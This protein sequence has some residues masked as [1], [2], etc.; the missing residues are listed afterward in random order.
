MAQTQMQDEPLILQAEEKEGQTSEG[1][2][3]AG[4]LLSL[5]QLAGNLFDDFGTEIVQDAVDDAGN[6]WIGF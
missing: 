2:R 3:S 5:A 1:V 6:C 4:T